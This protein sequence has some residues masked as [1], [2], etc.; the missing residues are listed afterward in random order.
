[1]FKSHD[2]IWDSDGNG[3]TTDDLRLITGWKNAYVNLLIKESANLTLSDFVK[4]W[5][6]KSKNRRHAVTV[7]DS[8][9][10]VF[11]MKELG[12]ILGRSKSWTIKIKKK[13]HLNTVEEFIYFIKNP[14]PAEDGLRARSTPQNVPSR[15]LKFD[16]GKYCYRGNFGI[17]CENYNSC[18]D[19]R[20]YHNK[21][22]ERYEEDGSCFKAE[23]YGLGYNKKFAD[24]CVAREI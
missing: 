11:S 21:H 12:K 1:M 16:R 15:A 13:F 23:S 7:V 20:L 14:P 22:H 19:V 10:D 9:G 18:M 4:V 3:F 2:R 17:I 5:Q 8:Y 6:R 24:M